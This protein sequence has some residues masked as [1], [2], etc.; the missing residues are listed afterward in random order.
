MYLNLITVRITSRR[1]IF[2]M[3]LSIDE[4]ILFSFRKSGRIIESYIFNKRFNNFS[5]LLKGIHERPKENN[6]E[7][8]LSSDLPGT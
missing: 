8:K 6:Y 7:N 5:K 3:L 1:D 2:I 4:W